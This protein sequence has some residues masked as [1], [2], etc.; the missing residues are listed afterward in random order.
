MSSM[1]GA[2]ARDAGGVPGICAA[3]GN[4]AAVAAAM[5]SLWKSR[6]EGIRYLCCWPIY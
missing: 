3:A 5:E 6:R 4:A 2:A 1:R